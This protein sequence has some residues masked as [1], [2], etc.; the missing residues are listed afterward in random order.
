MGV[1]AQRQDV[2]PVANGEEAVRQDGRVLLNHLLEAR[3]QPRAEVVDLGSQLAQIRA[4][5]IGDGAVGLDGSA[6]FVGEATEGGIDGDRPVK[7]GQLLTTRPEKLPERGRGAEG[8]LDVTKPRTV[9]APL[10]GDP[11]KARANVTDPV[12]GERLGALEEEERLGG[13]AHRDS[14][15]FAGG[16]ERDLTLLGPWR[17]EASPDGVGEPPPLQIFESLFHGSGAL[18]ITLA[19]GSKAFEPPSS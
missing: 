1:G 18:L 9:E 19:R 8:H 3:H 11:R 6:D 2:A 16:R 12:E 15:A 5:A 7:S 17:R 4:R 10:A 13:L 14:R